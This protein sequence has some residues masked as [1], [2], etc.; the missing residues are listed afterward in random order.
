VQCIFAGKPVFSS[1][2]LS[3]FSVAN[4][5]PDPKNTS[6]YCSG[7][8]SINYQANSKENLTFYC[9]V[10]SLW[11]FIYTE[12]CECTSVQQCCGSGMFIP[13]IGKQF[14]LSRISDTNFFYPGSASKNFSSVADPGCLSRITDPTFFHPGSEL[15]PSRIPDPQRI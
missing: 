3:G 9:F 15:S 5:H 7:Y 2:S 6:A 10:T 4:P 8:G 1:C 13:D 14:F 11:L 12:L